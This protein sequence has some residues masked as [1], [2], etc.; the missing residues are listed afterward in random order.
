[1]KS[2]IQ[3][4]APAAAQSSSKIHPGKV[5]NYNVRSNMCSQ[6]SQAC[7][8]STD[9]PSRSRSSATTS[10]SEPGSSSAPSSKAPPLSSSRVAML[11]PRP[12]AS[13]RSASSGP[14]S[15]AWGWSQTPTWMRYSPASLPDSSPAETA[16]RRSTAPIRKWPSSSWHRG[17][18]SMSPSTPNAAQ[19][20]KPTSPLGIFAPGY[21]EL[22]TLFGA[23]LAELQQNPEETGCKH[24]V[25][26]TFCQSGH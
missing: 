19:D 25:Q 16:R 10:A 21:K 7:H 6:F 2:P 4:F 5:T 14:V 23:L 18:T 8:L 12:W 17:Q 1:M 24:P 11:W 26:S 3:P 22:S 20:A 15:C 13:C 9:N